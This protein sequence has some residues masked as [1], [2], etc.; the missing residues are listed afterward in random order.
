MELEIDI[1]TVAVEATRTPA[2]DA[3][4]RALAFARLVDQ[5]LD[6]TYRLAAV[7]LG[8]R[9]EAE[10][11][12]H[13]AALRAWAGFAGLRDDARF[14][15]WF[16]RIVVNVCRDRLR[17]RRRGKVV[18]LGPALLAEIDGRVQTPD[19]SAA[20]AERDAV[21]RA[22]DRLSPDDRIVIALRYWRDLSVDSV[23][24]RLS[25]PVGTAKSRLHHALQRLRAE[26][27]RDGW[28]QR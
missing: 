20:V 24:V 13:D 5:Q 10:D 18:D 19:E 26:L 25:I 4:A 12:V 9:V 17:A 27:E 3:S 15:A 14:E 22:F 23:A 7:I 16:G 28:H 1:R 21:S 2:S 8:D 6:A 11:A